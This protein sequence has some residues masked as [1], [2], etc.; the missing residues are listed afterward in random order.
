MANDL[1]LKLRLMLQ[2]DGVAGTVAR[3]AAAMA[4]LRKETAALAQD[5]RNSLTRLREGMESVSRQLAGI[6]R[7]AKGVFVAFQGAGLAR[8]IIRTAAD[9]EG[10]QRMKTS[11]IAASRRISPPV[12]EPPSSAASGAAPASAATSR[13]RMR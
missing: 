12:H 7:M 1:T 2:D 4:G 6:E 8:G 10:A 13:V 5:S 9:G 11:A 3:A